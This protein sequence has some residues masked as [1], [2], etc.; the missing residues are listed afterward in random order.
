MLLLATIGSMAWARTPPGVMLGLAELERNRPRMALQRFLDVLR[1]D[2]EEHRARLGMMRAYDMLGRCDRIAEVSAELE[3][4]RF[5]M[6]DAMMAAG[7]CEADVGQFESARALL[8]EAID[9]KTE[10]PEPALRLARLC[11]LTGDL[12]CIADALDEAIVRERG[13]AWVA[14]VEAE[15]AVMAGDPAADAMLVAL[16]MYGF[17]P[18]V[19]LA[20]AEL[21]VRRLM[22]VGEPAEAAEHVKELISADVSS[23]AYATLRAET[24]RRAGQPIDALAPFGRPTIRLRPD[25]VEMAAVRARVLVDLGDLDEAR[26]VLSGAPAAHPEVV[27][28]W[29]YLSRARG[30]DE[31]AQ[32]HLARWKA[33]PLVGHRP[34]EMLIPVVEDH[35]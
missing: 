35:P 4:T 12:P 18:E 26:A 32:R 14:V 5:W 27:A 17:L 21:R 22:D 3:V 34:L 16:G 24:L 30:D 20:A 1:D 15:L 33:H 29:W 25:T 10:S 28:S 9:R 23:Q 8:Q 11:A 6:P 7:T 19:R 2:P 13:P 31:A